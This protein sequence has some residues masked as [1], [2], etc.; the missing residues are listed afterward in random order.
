MLSLFF[1]SACADLS[2]VED[3]IDLAVQTWCSPNKDIAVSSVYDGDTFTYIEDGEDTKIRMLGVAAPEV[4]DPPECY[5]EQAGAFLRELVLYED[6]RLEFDVETGNEDNPC[7]DI[8]NR[9]LAWVI[10]EGNDPDIAE[11]MGLYEMQGLNEDGS[12]Q[13]LVNELLVRMGYARVFQGEVDKSIRYRTRMEDAEE[14]AEEDFL[15]LW[16]VCE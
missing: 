7:A 15:G 6:V 8:Y 14:A 10:L 2:I 1:L 11:W 9:T 13:L 5:G 4:A 12:Y 3:D 16:L